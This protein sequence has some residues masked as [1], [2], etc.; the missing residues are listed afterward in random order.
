MRSTRLFELLEQL[1][2]RTLPVTAAEL[3]SMLGVSERTIYRD[4]ASLQALGA[5][6]RG[7]AGFG[8][9]LER[10][11]FLPPLR[12][13][14]DELDAV[15]L[16]LQWAASQAD[17]ALASGAKRV[18]GKLRASLPEVDGDR[19]LARPL[20]QVASEGALAPGDAAK[21]AKLR[22]AIREL[23]KVELR[24]QGGDGTAIDRVTRPLGLFAFGHVWLLAAWCEVR[25]DFRNFRLDRIDKLVMTDVLFRPERGRRLEDMLARM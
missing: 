7:E 23:R 9:L 16:G 25:S 6:I 22:R 3:A 17:P 20:R 10:G 19:L 13:D 18:A 5:P 11:A 2:G 15:M 4:V 8:Y 1:R 21:F 12:F 24:Y 14:G